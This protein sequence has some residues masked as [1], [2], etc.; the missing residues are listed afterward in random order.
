MVR[1][2]SCVL[3]VSNEQLSNGNPFASIDGIEIMLA[4]LIRQ[5]SSTGMPVG[6]YWLE[7]MIS[8]EEKDGNYM[9]SAIDQTLNR[10]KESFGHESEWKGN[11]SGGW[12]SDRFEVRKN[13]IVDWALERP[14]GPQECI[15][16]EKH[17]LMGSELCRY[18]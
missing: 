6:I 17:K 14:D 10:F 4:Y 11:R 1:I 18:V 3:D 8:P 12:T 16:E 15:S 5:Q 2:K 9:V 13:Q 7:R